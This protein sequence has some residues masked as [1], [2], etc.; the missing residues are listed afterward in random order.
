MQLNSLEKSSTDSEQRLIL[1]GVSWQQY[2][3]LRLTLDD[4]PGLRITYLEGTLEIMT[5]SPEHEISKKT[6]AFI[7]VLPKCIRPQTLLSK[8][9]KLIDISYPFH[10]QHF[11]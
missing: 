10:P 8:K 11:S 9:E 2:G 5:P 4:F 3:T 1:S 6:I 7:H